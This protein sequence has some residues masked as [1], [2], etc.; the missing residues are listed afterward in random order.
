MFLVTTAVIGNLIQF[1][2]KTG[3]LFQE[4]AMKI[5]MVIKN[6]PNMRKYAK[7]NCVGTPSD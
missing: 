6:V 1:V 7:L 5:C 4:N 3:I 2:F